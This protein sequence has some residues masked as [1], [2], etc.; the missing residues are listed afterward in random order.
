QENRVA[1]GQDIG[2]N[3]VGQVGTVCCVAG[4]PEAKATLHRIAIPRKEWQLVPP[5][6][7]EDDRWM[8]ASDRDAG[9]CRHGT[10]YRYV[11][12]RVMNVQHTFET[13]R[14]MQPVPEQ[15]TGCIHLRTRWNNNSSD[16]RCQRSLAHPS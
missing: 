1:F 8:P 16:N 11:Y 7:H 4:F 5:A 13:D 14:E 9:C 10:N 12:W 15:V 2:C 3:C 6:F